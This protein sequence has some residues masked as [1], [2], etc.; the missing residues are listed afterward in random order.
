MID[1][2]VGYT[3]SNTSPVLKQFLQRLDELVDPD[4]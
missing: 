4:Q 2:A 1:L 3:E